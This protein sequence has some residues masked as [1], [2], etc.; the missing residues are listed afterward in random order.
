MTG[1]YFWAGEQRTAVARNWT[2]YMSRGGE[3]TFVATDMEDTAVAE[4]LLALE[5]AGLAN[6][7]RLL[8]LRSGSDFTYPPPGQE[9]AG[10][11]FG[12]GHFFE[13]QANAAAHIAGSA[14]LAALSAGA[15]P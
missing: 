1:P 11:L 10:W 14:V 13:Q 7:S 2:D 8:V 15:R 6:A 9:L 12:G 5:S 3:A 4:A